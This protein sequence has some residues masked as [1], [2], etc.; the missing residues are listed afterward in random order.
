ML[1]ISKNLINYDDLLKTLKNNLNNQTLPQ[2]M[3]FSGTQGIGKATFTYFFLNQI[4]ESSNKKFGT[5]N[6]SH[7]IYNNSHPNILTINKEF[8]EKTKKIKNFITI[9][10][11]RNLDSF[12]Y[13]SSFDNLPKFIVIDSADDLNINSSNGLLKKLEE[14]KKNTYFILISHQLS[15]LS[16]TIRSRCIKFKFH[17]PN[18][19]QFKEIILNSSDSIEKFNCEF[20]YDIS[21]GSP[22][23]AL[24][25][26][27]EDINNTF[28]NLI[29]I[30]K[31]KK[32]FSSKILTLSNTVSTY[33]NE[34]YR[35][36]LSLIKFIFFNI[37]KI[38]LGV[39]IKENLISDISTPLQNLSK[40]FNNIISLKIL[41]YLNVNEK[42]LFVLN[43]DKRIFNLNLFSLISKT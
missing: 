33:N 18:L 37:I 11:I 4:F 17:N 25:L 3:I 24:K 13:Q 40:Y 5:S 30:L 39:N 41:E 2:A 9:D 38:N 10:Q 32:F 8:D 12:V 7:L 31:E 16:S 14:P 27:Y 23:L 42:D 20:L 28:N 26:Y 36:F 6:H 1:E 19:N 22:G 21:N 34:K 29:E 35:I 15:I 43:L